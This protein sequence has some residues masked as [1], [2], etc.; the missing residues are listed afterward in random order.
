MLSNQNASWEIGP[1]TRSCRSVSALVHVLDDGKLPVVRQLVTTSDVRVVAIRFS[2]TEGIAIMTILISRY[3]IELKEEVEFAS[4]SFEEKRAR[5][6]EA[7]HG[8]TLTYVALR[9]AVSLV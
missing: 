8:L 9:H 1:E 2:E 6:L 7:A 3:K 5:I 4:E